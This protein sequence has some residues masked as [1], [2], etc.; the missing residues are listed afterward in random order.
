MLITGPNKL[1]TL[2]QNAAAAKF[3]VP[4][5]Q[6]METQSRPAGRPD[7]TVQYGY[8]DAGQQPRMACA[9]VS[10]MCWRSTLWS[11]SARNS[12]LTGTLAIVP[13]GPVTELVHVCI[14][15]GMLHTGM[16]R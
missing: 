5:P 3:A 6:W 14:G 16:L 1:V 15:C 9:S 13:S 11:D 12:A 2:I 4:H 10:C 8:N 7:H